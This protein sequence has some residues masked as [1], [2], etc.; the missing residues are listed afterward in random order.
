MKYLDYTGLQYFW[1]KLKALFQTKQDVLVSGTNIKTVNGNSILGSGNIQAGDPDAIKYVSQTL[2][3]GQK[4]QARTNIGAAAASALSALETAIAAKYSKP[5]GGIPETDLASGVQSALA[6]AR[7]SIQSLADYYDKTQIDSL[8][9]AVSSEQY[10]D[11]T[12]LPT[13]SASTLGKIYLVGPDANGFYDRYY[14]SYDGSTYSWVAVG[15]TEIN[16]AN[17]ATKEELSQIRQDVDN[18]TVR[19]DSDADFDVIDE[20]GNV[21]ARFKDG[22]FRVK[23]FDSEKVVANLGT[24][25]VQEFD[26]TQTYQTDAVVRYNGLLYRFIVPHE[27]GDWDLSDVEQTNVMESVNTPV[28][29]SDSLNDADLDITD[30]NHYV[31]ARFK[32]GHIKTKKFDS[33]NIEKNFV[34]KDLDIFFNAASEKQHYDTVSSTTKNLSFP[35]DLKKNIC[36]ALKADFT[37][38]A[39]ITIGKGY[40]AYS[41]YW[42]VIDSTNISLY[43]NQGTTVL[44]KSVAHGLTF[45]DFVKIVI[46]NIG[47]DYCRFFIQ[48]KGGQFSYLFE[49]IFSANGQTFFTTAGT[50]TNVDFIASCSDLKNDIWV[51]GDSYLGFSNPA[52]WPKQLRNMGYSDYLGDGLAGQNS[53]G[54]YSDLQRCLALGVKPK[55]LVWTLGMNDSDSAWN[56]TYQQVKTLCE[57]NDITLILATVPTVPSRN[58]ENINSTVRNSGYDYIDFANAVGANSSGVW[59]SGYLSSDNVHPTELGAKALATQFIFDFILKH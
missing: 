34:Q 59:Y 23:N 11:V 36:F 45:S 52:R 53:S 10:I 33:E 49:W 22:N 25:S 32:N 14:T 56:T 43:Y 2:T 55:Y 6:L 40:N 8:L 48:T 29:V 9:A 39:T 19:T 26:T 24:D 37:T 42:F 30:E 35:Y 3:D 13:A 18:I 57:S 31:L 7:T 46:S 5:S 27:A 12:T 17:Y 28:S 51:F 41:G 15:N 21:L 20:G 50:L 4:Q 44:S 54:A 58:K 16:L 1:S 38:F 47:D